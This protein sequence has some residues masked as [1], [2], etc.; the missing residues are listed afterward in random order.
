[1]FTVRDAAVPI[2]A[3]HAPDS[4]LVLHPDSGVSHGNLDAGDLAAVLEQLAD[5]ALVVKSGQ[6]HHKDSV[7]GFHLQ[8]ALQVRLRILQLV[9]GLQFI[10]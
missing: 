9:N 8:F 6:S 7:P 2:V 3:Q 1:M 5:I 4:L 10:L